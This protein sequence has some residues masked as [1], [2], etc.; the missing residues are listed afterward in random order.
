LTRRGVTALAV[1]ILSLGACGG[2]NG[3]GDSAF[4]KQFEGVGQF[5]TATID[6]D[7]WCTRSILSPGPRGDDPY[8][9]AREC[10]RLIR[11]YDD[12]LPLERKV[13]YLEQAIHD[14]RLIDCFEC[15]DALYDELDRVESEG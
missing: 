5:S 9:T 13:N 4:D 10:I 2:G 6:L 11:R 14:A 7:S 15:V 1:L 12:E 3:D 8:G